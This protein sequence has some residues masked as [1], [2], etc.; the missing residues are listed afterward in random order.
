MFQ[1]GPLGASP[2]EIDFRPSI[3]EPNG[4]QQEQGTKSPINHLKIPIGRL[5]LCRNDKEVHVRLAT[6]WNDRNTED[7]THGLNLQ[8]FQDWAEAEDPQVRPRPLS[9]R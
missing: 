3:I 8:E 2:G 1:R 5:L 7:I 6:F 9:C 4:G